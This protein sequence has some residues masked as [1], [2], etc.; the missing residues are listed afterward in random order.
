MKNLIRGVA[1]MGLMAAGLPTGIAL[2]A[3]PCDTGPGIYWGGDSYAY[4][5]NYAPYVSQPGSQLKVLG[6]VAGMCEPLLSAI[7]YNPS[8]EYTFVLDNLATAAGTQTTIF[9]GF[10][11]YDTYYG[12][13]TFAIYEDASNDAKTAVAPPGSGSW[14]LPSAP[15]EAKFTNGTLLLAGTL[16]DISTSVSGLTGQVPNGSILGHYSYTG[17]SLY[18]AFVVTPSNNLLQGN[19]NPAP[20]SLPPGYSAQSTGKFDTDSPTPTR[21][22]TWGTI[23]SLYR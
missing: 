21:A 8:K 4:E 18:P 15:F 10:T 7:P 3:G 22:S 23:K 2:A 1:A 19:W 20:S 13:G 5:T 16:A 6:I 9:G 17:G 11:F 12:S 14:P